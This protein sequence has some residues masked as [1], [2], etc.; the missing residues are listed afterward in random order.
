MLPKTLMIYFVQEVIG[1]SQLSMNA[2]NSLWLKY[3]LPVRR[4]YGIIKLNSDTINIVRGGKQMVV[5]MS[6]ALSIYTL[7]YL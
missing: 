2:I 7:W 6:T 4:F 3:V 5:H 1:G